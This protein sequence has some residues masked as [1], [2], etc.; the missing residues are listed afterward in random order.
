MH[1]SVGK[2]RR[3]G[4][5]GGSG[6]QFPGDMP[7]MPDLFTCESGLAPVVSG[8]PPAGPVECLGLMFPDDAARRQ[9]FLGILRAKLK[10]PEFRKIEGFPHGSDED[11]LALS[12]PP[13]YTAC[14]NP[15]ITDF[16]RHYGKPYD[17]AT[18]TYRREPFAADVS[19]G[20]NDPIYNAHAYHTKVPHKAI[21]RYILHYTEPGDVVLDGFCG[22]GMTGVAAQMCGNKAVVESLGYQVD[23]DGTICRLETDENGKTVWKPFSRLGA[24]RAVLG[25]LSPAATFIAYNYNTPVDVAGFAR[26]ARRILEEVEAECGWMYRT[27]RTEVERRLPEMWAERLHT[28]RTAEDVRTLIGSQPAFFGTVNYTVWSD[29]FVCPDCTGEVVFWEAAVDKE[30]G[31]VGDEFPC[32]HCRAT[33]T[34][35]RMERAWVTKYDQALQKPIR[36]A[37]QAPVLINYSVGKKRFEKAPDAFD[38]ALIRKIEQLE[39]PDWFPTD[40]MPD[41]YNT[42]QPKVSHAF[43]HVHHFYTRRNLWVLAAI[44]GRISSSGRIHSTL[45]LL[46]SS[47]NLTHSTMMSRIIF[48]SEG[49][50]PILTGYQSGT[51]YVSSIPVEKNI[52]KSINN[53]KMDLI[54]AALRGIVLSNCVE[55]RSSSMIDLTESSVDYIFTDPPFGGNLMYSELNFLWESWLR[56]FTN[57]KPEAIENSIHGKGLP[58]YQKLMTECFREYYRVLKPGRWMTVEFHNSKHAVWNAIQ[59]ALQAAGFVI[60]DVRTLDKKQ[61]SFKQVTSASAV[62]QDLIISCYKSNGGLERRFTLKA[63][64]EEG[65][66]DFIRTHLKQLPVF[67]SRD[68]QAEVIAERQSYLLFD[69]MVAFHVQ[70]GVT[71]PMSASEFYAGLAQRFSERD[72]MYFLPDQVAEYDRERRGVRP[73]RQPG[74]FVTGE[75]S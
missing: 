71:I 23:K 54:V 57:S 48:K 29:V 70:R 53:M 20:R 25:D 58:E 75:S 17:P 55:T 13:Y 32:P 31:K 8:S 26:E 27:L 66:W 28:C 3:A 61:G 41:G 7:T 1:S 73:V 9:H 72:G 30:A 42:E 33:L 74:F 43:T 56:V 52:I 60:A 15:F 68:G 46:T 36:Q 2:K 21:M 11:I 44:T 38:L 16:I 35:R 37:R 64:T 49:N 12:D 51:L 40:R 24:R 14:P 10:D 18:D 19:E 5:A 39:I 4:R 59:E 34:K 65:V 67:V 45:R 63:G 6:Q 47:Y 62:K 22:T 69:R 50:K